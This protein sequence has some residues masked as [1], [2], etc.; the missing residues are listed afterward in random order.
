MLNRFG[1]RDEDWQHTPAFVQQAFSSLYHQLLLLEIRSHAYERQ[2]A[3]LRDQVAQIDDLK[4]QLAELRERLGQTPTTPLNHLHPT[5]RS[6]AN[7]LSVSQ[8]AANVVVI[9]VIPEAVES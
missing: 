6:N 3:Q 7:N 2:L 5:R 8:Q 4:V 1:I 9:P